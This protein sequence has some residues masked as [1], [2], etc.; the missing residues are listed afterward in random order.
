MDSAPK[1][2]IKGPKARKKPKKITADYLHNSG[3][4]YLQRFSA[5]RSQFRTVM[6]RKVR[7]SCME[8]KD[9]N[10]EDCMALV[11]ETIKKFERAGL[12]NDELYT[13]GVVSS[14]RRQG[15]SK[16][17]ILTK[18]QTRGI[19]SAL[20][21]E[22]LETVD[23]E[24]EGNA[25]MKAALMVLRRKKSGPFGN[26]KEDE[27]ILAALARAGFSYDTAQRAMRMDRDEA[28]EILR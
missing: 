26:N 14:L 27:K 25:E 9:Q 18:L 20:T 15:K 6:T 1:K 12:L 2:A 13:Q 10:F 23:S 16:R 17:A 3:L 11:E 4:Y 24:N 22:K 8:H 19:A 28:E 7:R 21:L 5:S